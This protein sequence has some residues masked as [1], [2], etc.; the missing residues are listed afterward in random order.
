ME[1]IIMT[2]ADFFEDIEGHILESYFRQLVISYHCD[3]SNCPQASEC[4][5]RIVHA[6]IEQLFTKKHTLDRFTVETIQ[7]DQVALI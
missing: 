5:D 7:D 6:Y 4:L 3:S 1:N 2:I